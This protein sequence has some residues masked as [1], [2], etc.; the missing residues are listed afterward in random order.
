[1]EAALPTCVVPEQH[2]NCGNADHIENSG[3]DQRTY[4]KN[5]STMYMY[6]YSHTQIIS[7]TERMVTLVNK[8]PIFIGC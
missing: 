7:K 3:K 6:T 5:T 1:M 4:N 8:E 2:E